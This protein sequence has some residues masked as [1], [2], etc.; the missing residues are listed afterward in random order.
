VQPDVTDTRTDE[1]YIVDGVF[2]NLVPDGGQLQWLRD[3]RPLNGHLHRRAAG[4]FQTRNDFVDVQTLGGFAIDQS[5]E[6]AYAQSNFLGRR[7]RKWRRHHGDL[8]ES[9]RHADAESV[10]LSALIFTQRV[11]RLG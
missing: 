9:D 6:I 7:A 8:A 1:E 5:D 4:P 11:E 3:A 10:V 2:R